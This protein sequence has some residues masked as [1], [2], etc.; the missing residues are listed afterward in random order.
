MG[1]VVAQVSPIAL[2]AI[3]FKFFFVFF[4]CNFLAV[5]FYVFCLPE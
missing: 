3:G 1:L 5:L 4:A 2:G